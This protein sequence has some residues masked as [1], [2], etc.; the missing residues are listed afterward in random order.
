MSG[1]GITAQI[2]RE[3]KNT[4]DLPQWAAHCLDQYD[5]LPGSAREKQ[6]IAKGQVI[7]A[8]QTCDLVQ[9]SV[10][11]YKKLNHVPATEDYV[12]FYGNLWPAMPEGTWYDSGA[13]APV[14]PVDE[15]QRRVQRLGRRF[16]ARNSPLHALKPREFSPGHVQSAARARGGTIS[17]HNPRIEVDAQQTPGRRGAVRENGANSR[18]DPGVQAGGGPCLRPRALQACAQSRTV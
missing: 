17:K 14:D 16:R 18:L 12:D 3:L 2:M 11:D 8:T 6:E 15:Q 7:P 4:E 9:R 13:R 10:R 5:R 1:S